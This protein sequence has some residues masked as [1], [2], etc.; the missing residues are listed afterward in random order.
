MTASFLGSWPSQRAPVSDRVG[1]DLIAS[2]STSTSLA[3]YKYN[4]TM[5]YSLILKLYTIALTYV[6]G[7]E[8]SSASPF[9]KALDLLD[10]AKAGE[11]LPQKGRVVE[12]FRNVLDVQCSVCGVGLLS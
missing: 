10:K 6:N 12:L 7:V 1:C 8:Y 9:R 11:M 2:T 4:H 5:S 3:I